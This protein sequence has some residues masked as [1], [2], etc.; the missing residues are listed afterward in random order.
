[1][2]FSEADSIKRISSHKYPFHINGKIYVRLPPMVDEQRVLPWGQIDEWD[3][4]EFVIVQ[5]HP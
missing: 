4:I 2:F 1:M 3:I 5:G